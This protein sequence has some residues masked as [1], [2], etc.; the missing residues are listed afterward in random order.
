MFVLKPVRSGEIL[1]TDCGQSVLLSRVRAAA[2]P[3]AT[4]GADAF[5]FQQKATILSHHNGTA[6][7]PERKLHAAVSYYNDLSAR[8]YNNLQT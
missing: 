5:I 6:P 8:D 1:I 2:A 4:L 7:P 3:W